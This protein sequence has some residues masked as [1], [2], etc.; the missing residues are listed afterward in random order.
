MNEIRDIMN[1]MEWGPAPESPA[2]AYQAF[3]KAYLDRYHREPGF[4]GVYAYDATQVVLSALLAQQRGQS[5]KATVLK[6]RTF[7]GLQSDFSF[8]DFGDVRRSHASISVVR[9]KKFVVVE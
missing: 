9:N 2:P 6:L 8:D 1:T 5:L 4:P 7:S 3:R